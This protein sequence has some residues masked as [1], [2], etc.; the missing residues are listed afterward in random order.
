[1]LE[2]RSASGGAGGSSAATT[3]TS[4]AMRASVERAAAVPVPALVEGDGGEPVRAQAAREVV[5][6]LLARA[7]AVQ[8]DDAAA[9]LA[10]GQE[11]R[12]GEARRARRSRRVGRR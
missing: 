1:M 4:A 3:A 5:V 12:V 8:D 10:V 9:R 11:E 2:P 6:R 7:R